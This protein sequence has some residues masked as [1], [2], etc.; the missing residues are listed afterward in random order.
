M[1]PVRKLLAHTALASC[2]CVLRPA[3]ADLTPPPGRMN[4]LVAALPNKIGP[5]RAFSA[6]ALIKCCADGAELAVPARRALI[7]SWDNLPDFEQQRLI[8]SDWPV[9]AGP[10]MIPILKKMLSGPI[11]EEGRLDAMAHHD[12]L[13]HLFE[14]APAEARPF[15]DRDLRES[16][17][18]PPVQLL[19]LLREAEL[20][21]AIQ[22][23]VDRIAKDHGDKDDFARA[24]RFAIEKDLPQISAAFEWS[25]NAKRCDGQESMIRYFIRVDPT[26]IG[27]RWPRKHSMPEGTRSLCL[28]SNPV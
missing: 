18:K 3:V 8:T 16:G 7:G 11:P 12:A 23:S 9:L 20:D 27:R 2:P 6:E 22:P 19:E 13:K 28:V 1:I 24:E 14:L 21:A 10:E 17:T 26:H 5:A 15:I 4:R 25:L